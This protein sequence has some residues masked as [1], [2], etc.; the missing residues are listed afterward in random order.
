[1]VAA[2]GVAPRMVEV[3]GGVGAGAGEVPE[4]LLRDLPAVY[5]RR[6]ARS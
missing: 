3:E 4:S 2:G 1:M 6:D 5:R